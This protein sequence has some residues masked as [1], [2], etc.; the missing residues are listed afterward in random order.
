[1]LKQGRVM[2]SGAADEVLTPDRIR[3]LYEVDVEIARHQ[4]T[5]RLTV[6]PLRQSEP[7]PPA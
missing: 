6:V 2:A 5:G 4:G 3:E 1:M 7:G